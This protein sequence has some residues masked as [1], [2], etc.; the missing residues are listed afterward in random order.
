MKNITQI[1][2]FALASAYMVSCEKEERLV[3]YPESYPVYNQAEVSESVITYGDSITVS[4]NV[5]D[6]GTPLSTLEV[7][8]VINNE[9]LTSE[10]IRTKGNSAELTRRYGV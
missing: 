5:S 4:V 6:A 9:L 2:L 8:I 10:V 3:T 7:Q 1:F